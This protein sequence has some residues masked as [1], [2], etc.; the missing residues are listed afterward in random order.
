MNERETLVTMTAGDFE[1]AKKEA[2]KW[3]IAHD[4][5]RT[6]AEIA[7]AEAARYPGRLA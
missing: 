6:R 5:Q 4:K 2:A 3:Q 7:E 1:R